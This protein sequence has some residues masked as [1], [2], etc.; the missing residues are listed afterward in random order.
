MRKM[1]L[2]AGFMV[3]SFHMALGVNYVKMD[4]GGALCDLNIS[5]ID[6]L[7]IVSDTD[8]LPHAFKIGAE[9]LMLC[10][11]LMF[12]NPVSA[13]GKY[14]NWDELNQARSESSTPLLIMKSTKEMKQLADLIKRGFKTR[15]VVVTGRIGKKNVIISTGI[16][17]CLDEKDKERVE[18]GLNVE[19]IDLLDIV[20][21]WFPRDKLVIHRN[22]LFEHRSL[23]RLE[24]QIY[25]YSECDA[26]EK[27]LAEIK[28]R[29]LC[30]THRERY[31]K[32]IGEPPK[33]TEGMEKFTKETTKI[34]AKKKKRWENQT[35]SVY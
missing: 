13:S 23:M 9:F 12:A 27:N 1:I 31:G 3:A 15:N 21:I 7:K 30:N 20:Y 2:I 4:G 18:R 14:K 17:I 10:R 26:K 35:C 25:T 22:N 28:I 29:E 8:D 32:E 6:D 11:T 16:G 19:V 34:I 24:E 33:T 5:L